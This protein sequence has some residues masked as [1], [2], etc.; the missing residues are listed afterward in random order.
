MRGSSAQSTLTGQQQLGPGKGPR[1]AGPFAITDEATHSELQLRHLTLEGSHDDLMQDGRLKKATSR[2]R[3]PP[4]ADE[5]HQSKDARR[6]SRSGSGN[7]DFRADPLSNHPASGARLPGSASYEPHEASLSDQPYKSYKS[8]KPHLSSLESRSPGN[9]DS[10]QPSPSL[11]CFKTSDPSLPAAEDIDTTTI[12]KSEPGDLEFSAD[13]WQPKLL[14]QPDSRPISQSQL[15]AE[16]KSIYAG[17]VMVENKCIS[18]DKAQAAAVQEKDRTQLAPLSDKHWQALIAL[19]RTLLHEHHD[20]FLASQHPSATPAL[21]RLALKYSMPARM[22]K[23][24]IHSFLELLRKRLPESLEYMLCFIC[25][26]YH[27]V[28]LLYETVPIFSD[29]WRE[30]LGDISR[31]RMA[32]EDEDMRD[33]EVWAGMGRSWYGEA[34]DENPTVGRL[35]HHLAILAR[36]YALQQLFFYSRSLACIQPFTGTRDSIMTLLDPVIGTTRTTYAHAADIDIIYIKAHGMLITRECLE[37]FDATT[38]DYLRQL[39]PYIGRV[40]AKW[41]DQGIYVA[42]INISSLFS[43]GEEGAVL[44]KY[45][46]IKFKREIEALTRPQG[47][48][49][50]DNVRV[51]T[52]PPE[53]DTADVLARQLDL[54]AQPTFAYALR[55]TFSTFRLT[56]QRIGDKNVFPHIHCLLVFLTRVSSLNYD[57]SAIFEHVPWEALAHFLNTLAKTDN[58]E[59]PVERLDF[60]QQDAADKRPLPEDYLIRGQIWSLDYFPDTWF[61]TPVDEDERHLELASTHRSRIE[62]I[63]WLGMR[64]VTENGALHFDHNKHAWAANGAVPPKHDFTRSEPVQLGRNEELIGSPN[65][66]A[67]LVMTGDVSTTTLTDIYDPLLEST[68]M[69][70][71]TSNMPTIKKVIVRNYTV[72]ICETDMLLSQTDVFVLLLSNGDWR[73]LIPEDVIANLHAYA[74]AMENDTRRVQAEQALTSI[75]TALSQGKNLSIVDSQGNAITDPCKAVEGGSSNATY[76]IPLEKMDDVIIGITRRVSDMTLQEPGEGHIVPG[77]KPAVLIAEN[78]QTRVKARKEGLTS[79]ASAMIRKLLSSQVKR[80]G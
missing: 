44:R 75:N 24:A 48:P 38:D 71:Q 29:T 57:C 10:R 80:P 17:L 58:I 67:D 47:G 43:H 66:S 27:M 46:D 16:V 76:E 21:Q 59:L 31:Y 37:T 4:P 25:L 14:L 32:V 68:K 50:D 15:A 39:D 65:V 34:A 28:A 35:Y 73:V 72:I 2:K 52:P 60:P 45:F 63:L 62:R 8:L 36:P 54:V 40:S 18:V 41:A 51:I 70:S 12:A 74:H 6:T 33:R 20:F 53:E 55:I 26:A 30:C 61:E 22:W 56:L 3:H 19:H 23:H 79:V 42:V 11:E 49:N 64:L 7:L 5:I 78:R 69:S 1:K 13:D 77:A 9:P